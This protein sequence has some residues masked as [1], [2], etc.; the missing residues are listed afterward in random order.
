[1]HEKKLPRRRLL[2][3]GASL[4]AVAP[5]VPR[6][7]LGAVPL[8]QPPLPFADSALAPTISGQTVQIHYGKH[9]ATY[10]ANLNRMVANTPYADLSVEQI[11]MK[12]A[13]D[14]QAKGLFNQAGQAWNHDFYWQ[15]LKPGGSRAP[16]GKLAQAID[17]DFGGFDKFK[18]AFAQRANGV[19]GSGWAWLVEDGGKLALAET[20]NADTPLA[21]GKRAL[22]T[23]DVWEHAYYLDYQNRRADH[24]KAV[25]DN[26][27]NWDFV[28]DRMTI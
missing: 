14:A 22:A 2:R 9:H 3:A 12:A 28:R 10:Y 15:V 21:H 20:S 17:R 6:Y 1:M 18:E 24:V 8:A 26:L 11:V 16:T 25:L 13:G 23:I 4:L 19:F 7:A 27:I 5:M